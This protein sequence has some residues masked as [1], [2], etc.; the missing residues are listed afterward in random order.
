MIAVRGL[1]PARERDDFF[2]AGRGRMLHL[3]KYNLQHRAHR[4]LQRP[5]C[6]IRVGFFRW[7]IQIAGS[8]DQAQAA[9]D[10]PDARARAG[11]SGD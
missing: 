1:G 6:Q 9:V 10:D 2:V 11:K 8:G 5:E 7:R 3:L 4:A